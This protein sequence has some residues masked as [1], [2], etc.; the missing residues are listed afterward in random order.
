MQLSEFTVHD[1]KQFP[2]VRCGPESVR[3]G[4]ATQW[5]MELEALI[6]R[7]E[8]FFMLFAEGD[9]KEEPEDTRIRAIWLK[10]NKLSLS[11]VCRSIVS[12]EP[13][14]TK[15][16]KLLEQLPGLERAFG[17]RRLVASTESEAR[18]VG[19]QSLSSTCSR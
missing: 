17:I 10:Q 18:M 9:F 7:D 1:V 19:L 4:Y 8:P 14:T 2:A 6:E 16:A 3:P 15:R 12:I 11:R 13:D 5:R